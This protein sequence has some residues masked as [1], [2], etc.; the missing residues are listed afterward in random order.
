MVDAL[1]LCAD[2]G[3]DFLASVEPHSLQVLTYL[4]ISQATPA[5]TVNAT[6]IPWPTASSSFPILRQGSKVIAS[7]A[8]DIIAYIKEQGFNTD[9]HLSDQQQTE[10]VAFTALLEDRLLPAILY[11]RWLDS[12]N[13]LECTRRHHSRLIHFPLSL[14]YLS[15]RHHAVQHDVMRGSPPEHTVEQV[16]SELLAKAVD[17]LSLLSARLGEN[18]YFFGERPSSLDAVLYGYLEVVLQSPLPSGNSLQTRLHSHTNLQR[19]CEALRR[20]HFP[21]MKTSVPVGS[22]APSATSTSSI[23]RDPT[24]WASVCVALALLGLQGWRVG[25]FGQLRQWYN[26]GRKEDAYH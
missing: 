19:Y 3:D 11:S 12:Q 18:E 15:W 13:Y 16:G 22:V 24:L 8:E 1:E 9:T 5:V 2:A 25:L 20:K 10:V 6:G 14:L 23:W 21:A 26:S 7:R 4:K 17:C